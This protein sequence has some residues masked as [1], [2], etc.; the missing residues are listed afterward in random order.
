MEDRDKIPRIDDECISNQSLLN[1]RIKMALLPRYKSK[2]K[3]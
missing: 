3:S 2:V 1:Y